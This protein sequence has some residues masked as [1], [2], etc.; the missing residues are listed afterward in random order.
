MI[1]KTTKNISL[2][3][4]SNHNIK[5]RLFETDIVVIHPNGNISLYGANW[6]TYTTAKHLNYWLPEQWSV[7]RQGDEMFLAHRSFS[8]DSYGAWDF[9]DGMTLEFNGTGYD[10]ILTTDDPRNKETT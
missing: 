1:I 7:Y 8:G 2:R 9:V 5:V 4:D 10:Y 3:R 6:P